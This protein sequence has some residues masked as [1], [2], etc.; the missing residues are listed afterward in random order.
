MQRKPSKKAEPEARQYGFRWGQVDVVRN[1]E[2]RGLRSLSIV[3]EH[4]EIEIGVSAGGRSIRVY[5][6]G[7]ELH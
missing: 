5:R 1:M 2:Y 6:D 7:K 4:A 3:T